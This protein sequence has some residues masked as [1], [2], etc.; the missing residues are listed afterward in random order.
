MKNFIFIIALLTSFYCVSQN[1][2]KFDTKFTQSE[3]KW[4][5]FRPDS[6]GS[7]IFGFI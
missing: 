4:V 3:D 5:A 7:H 2:L 1:D 6:V